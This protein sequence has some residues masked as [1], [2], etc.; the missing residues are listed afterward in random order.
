MKQNELQVS[1]EYL[2]VSPHQHG[3]P[4]MRDP[5]KVRRSM[6]PVKVVFDSLLKYKTSEY[7]HTDISVF[8]LAEKGDRSTGFLARD[9]H[10]R[11]MVISARNVIG[12]AKPIEHR[13]QVEE[14]QKRREEEIRMVRE[15]ER[16]EQQDKSLKE[17]E[18]DFKGALNALIEI[19]RGRIDV[20]RV[21]LDTSA[22]RYRNDFNNGA[23]INI[24]LK[25]MTKIIE[26]YFQM[27]D[28]VDA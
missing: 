22:I 2:A 3:H 24:P 25:T 28:E 27:K 4:D 10:G 7:V 9:E 13:W 5:S 15:R 1:V 21:S 17:A 23:V 8:A 16:V 20:D 14:E 6:N 18:R 19:T 11:L 12:E 26:S